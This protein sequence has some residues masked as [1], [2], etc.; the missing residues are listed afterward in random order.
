MF[1]SALLQIQ[2]SGSVLRRL[3]GLLRQIIE[4][5]AGLTISSAPILPYPKVSVLYLFLE[6]SLSYQPLT[7]T[8]MEIG[9]LLPLKPL[10]HISV[11][12]PTCDGAGVALGSSLTQMNSLSKGPTLKEGI[13]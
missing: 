13:R 9:R 12:I 10:I 2:F 3:S 7:L 4:L 11:W 8:L 5:T 6:E 1:L